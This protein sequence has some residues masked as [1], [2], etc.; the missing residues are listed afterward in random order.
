MREMGV[1]DLH[2][3]WMRRYKPNEGIEQRVKDVLDELDVDSNVH[4]SACLD[5]LYQLSAQPFARDGAHTLVEKFWEVG[6]EVTI[7]TQGDPAYQEAKVHS[8]FSEEQR[9]K[10]SFII[11]ENKLEALSKHVPN[12]TQPH[13]LVVDDKVP[14]LEKARDII[15]ERRP[16]VSV[17]T[18]RPIAPSA[19]EEGVDIDH[20]VDDL[21]KLLQPDY[22]SLF[23]DDQLVYLDFDRTL[24]DPDKF[25]TH[26]LLPAIQ[27]FAQKL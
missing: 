19:E 4:I 2:G 22:D 23:R 15:L 25:T 6:T 16:E 5:E 14:F 17:T 8:F 12:T 20:E 27:S 24:F 18:V 11:A 3:A 1:K 26:A 21:R 9:E 7:W 13:I 10:L